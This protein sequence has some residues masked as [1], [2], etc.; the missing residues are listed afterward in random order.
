MWFCYEFLDDVCDLFTYEF[1][2]CFTSNATIICS[3]SWCRPTHRKTRTVCIFP[4]KYLFL[5]FSKK[6]I[7][8]DDP[9]GAEM[10]RY[11]VGL[12]SLVVPNMPCT[13][14]SRY[15]LW[16]SVLYASSCMKYS[17]IL[18]LN[19]PYAGPMRKRNPNLF[20]TVPAD[21]HKQ[22]RE[23]LLSHMGFFSYFLWLSMIWCHM[24]TW[25]NNRLL[26]NGAIF[27]IN[28]IQTCL[29]GGTQI[30]VYIRQ[31]HK[32]APGRTPVARLT[33]KLDGNGLML[34]HQG[35]FYQY[36]STLIHVWISNHIHHI[37]CEMKLLIR[38]KLERCSRWSLRMD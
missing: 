13:S 31:R 15:V 18:V 3:P 6:Y 2:C 26:G 24:S 17:D 22:A 4:E 35:P 29:V 25:I 16:G 14:L 11:E 27:S 34:C 28:P 1:T 38:S 10:L 36:N 21:G 37:K 12:Y 9:I 5:V 7:A 30:N 20:I 23:L 8:L 19:S 32:R 33:E